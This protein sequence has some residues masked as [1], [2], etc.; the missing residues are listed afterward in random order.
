MP[1]QRGDSHPSWGA[2]MRIRH[3]VSNPA[4]S[5]PKPKS[6]RQLLQSIADGDQRAMEALFDRHK[7]RVHR[8]ALRIVRDE[9]LAEDVTAETFCQVWRTASSF[10]GDSEALTWLMAIARNQAVSALRGRREREL[11]VTAASLIEDLSDT[12]EVAMVKEQQKAAV[13]RCLEGLSP[14]H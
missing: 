14:A 5:I 8:F 2:H 1:H 3:A 12:P 9:G 4:V 6:D 7:T 13:A 10:K 11:D